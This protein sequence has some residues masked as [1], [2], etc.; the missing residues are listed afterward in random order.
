MSEHM[1][2]LK[3]LHTALI[4]SR[5]GYQEALEDAEGKGLTPLFRDMITLRNHDADELAGHLTALGEKV[6]DDCSFMSTVHRTVIS[7]RSVLTGLE[8]SI[9]PALIDGEGRILE[10]YDD[11]LETAPARSAEHAV[12]V[13]QRET[14][15]RKIGEMQRRNEQAA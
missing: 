5:N 13:K 14:L 7:I 1:D 2:A 3:S 9:L 15:M 10:Y 8:E 12:L 11:A 6:D 4:D